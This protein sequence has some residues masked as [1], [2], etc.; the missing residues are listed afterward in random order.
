VFA[1]GVPKKNETVAR[2]MG[3]EPFSTVDAAL[4]EAESRL[5]KDCTIT[6][7][8]HLEEQTYFARVNVIAEIKVPS[9]MHG[10]PRKLERFAS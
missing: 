7:Y 2:H 1:A 8:P 3:F 9:W 4:R 6:Y 5:E 10:W